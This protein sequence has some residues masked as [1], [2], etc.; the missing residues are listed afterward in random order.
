MDPASTHGF[1][2][3]L[4][5]PDLSPAEADFSVIGVPDDEAACAKEQ[6]LALSESVSGPRIS[7]LSAKTAQDLE[8]SASVTWVI[9]QSRIRC[10][11]LIWSAKK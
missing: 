8:I 11:I 2:A 3:D 10:G 5:R 9:S 6:R 4:H 7:H 1:W